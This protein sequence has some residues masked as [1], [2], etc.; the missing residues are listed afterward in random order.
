MAKAATNMTEEQLGLPLPEVA[1]PLGELFKR[2]KR[3]RRSSKKDPSA[4]TEQQL[5]MI[6]WDED[7]EVSNQYQW[8]DNEILA[9]REGMLIDRIRT[10]LDFRNGL[11]TRSEIWR[12]IHS[13]EVAPFSF[14]VCVEACSDFIDYAE[15]RDELVNL[16]ERK[17]KVPVAK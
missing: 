3:K 15:W 10:L 16:I 7:W 4:L 17:G 2:P 14:R 13:D 12:W 11:E 5:M 8:T 1:T 6:L 9:L